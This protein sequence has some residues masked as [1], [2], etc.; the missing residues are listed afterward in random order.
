VT[1]E[2]T[3]DGTLVRLAA[4]TLAV[5]IDYDRNRI[6]GGGVVWTLGWGQKRTAAETLARGVVA[7][8]RLADGAPRIGARSGGPPTIWRWLSG[9]RGT[10]VED[11][12]QSAGL[13]PVE[14]WPDARDRPWSYRSDDRNA[15][16]PGQ[17]WV[18]A[19]WPRTRV[20]SSGD[21][22]TVARA[23]DAWVGPHE[24]GIRTDPYAEL[25]VASLP[26]RPARAVALLRSVLAVSPAVDD[27]PL[28]VCRLCGREVAPIQFNG[29]LD[30]CHSCAES[31]LGVRY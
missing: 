18:G 2:A 6:T 23:Q 24:I 21:T 11:V 3:E 22:I 12:L 10:W 8:S 15:D 4:G 13:E 5:E 30:A 31:R 28:H 19:A 26:A 25:A 14:R 7:A 17:R 16:P 20:L 27:R 1:R 29:S 9:A